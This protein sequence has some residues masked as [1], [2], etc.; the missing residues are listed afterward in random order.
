MQNKTKYSEKNIQKLL[1]A[2]FRK[3]N[4]LDEQLKKETLELLLQKVTQNRKVVQPE[5]KILV[6]LSVI[7][8]AF[9]IL[10]F[11][12]SRISIYMLDFIKPALGLSLV[13]IPISSI[14]LIILKKKPNEKKLV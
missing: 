3:E 1:N 13:F 7:W 8:I 4:Q 10:I 14:V 9:S 5:N 6:G 12:E 2:G 11:S